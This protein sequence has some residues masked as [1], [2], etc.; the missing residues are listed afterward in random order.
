MNAFVLACQVLTAPLQIRILLSS[1]PIISSGNYHLTAIF[2]R[3]IV[4]VW[5][6]ELGFLPHIISTIL[7]EPQHEYSTGIGT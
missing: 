1:V 4:T 6:L 3:V 2:I 7:P 5:F